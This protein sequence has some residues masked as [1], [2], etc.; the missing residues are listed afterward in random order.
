M[1]NFPLHLVAS[2]LLP[3]HETASAFV[4]VFVALNVSFHF[5]PV[6]TTVWSEV[7][8]RKPLSFLPLY[9]TTVTDR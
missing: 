4:V 6:F 8:S 9:V 1:F 5:L 7:G 3:F 2:L